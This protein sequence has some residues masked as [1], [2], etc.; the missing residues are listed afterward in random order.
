ML[1]KITILTLAAI[2]CGFAQT[3]EEIN[4]QLDQSSDEHMKEELGVNPI[5]TPSI[6][7]LLATLDNYRPVPLEV[8]ASNNRDAT[9]PNRLQTAIHFGTLISDGFMLTLA[10]RPQ[11]INDI[12][13]RDQHMIETATGILVFSILRSRI[14]CPRSLG[15]QPVD[16][17]LGADTVASRLG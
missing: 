7:E 6:R 3:A 8:I 13:A 17:A 4:Q 9:F 5:T 16:D 12:G 11:D 10:Q 1:R 2:T 14:G 15:R